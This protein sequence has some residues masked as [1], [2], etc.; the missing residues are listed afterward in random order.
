MDKEA[1]DIIA[2]KALKL[3][4]E[5]YDVVFREKMQEKAMD[6]VIN[7]NNGERFVPEDSKAGTKIDNT[8]A[9]FRN[10]VPPQNVKYDD[11]ECEEDS[12]A[13]TI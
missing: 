13:E 11:I 5:G 7:K 12:G 2:N 3:I 1:S 8:A 10:N 6:E 9:I 4:T